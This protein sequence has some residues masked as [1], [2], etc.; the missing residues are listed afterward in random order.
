MAAAR[1]AAAGASPL[2]ARARRP[3]R[4]AAAAVGGNGRGDAPVSAEELRLGAYGA[5]GLACEAVVGVSAAHVYSYGCGLPPGPAGLEGLGE[6]LSYLG[7]TGVLA[8]SLVTKVQTGSG[9]P[10]GRPGYQLGPGALL[11][12]AEGIA[13]LY[14]A[15]LALLIAAGVALGGVDAVLPPPDDVVCGAAREAADASPAARL[16]PCTYDA[17]ICVR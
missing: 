6:G 3:R 7:V 2:A 10:T 17:D 1:C 12:L 8:A 9:L 16:N 5:L 14:V 15:A 4:A 13:Y 11:G